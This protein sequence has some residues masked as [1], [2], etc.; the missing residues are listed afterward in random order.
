M[1][2]DTADDDEPFVE[3]TGSMVYD[4]ESNPYCLGSQQSSMML[5]DEGGTTSR[6]A[7]GATNG[8]MVDATLTVAEALQRMRHDAD[9]LKEL[10]FTSRTVAL[11][12]L[13]FF[14]WSLVRARDRFFDARDEILGRLRISDES[15]TTEP[16]V[17]RND[18][19]VTCCICWDDVPPNQAIALVSCSHWLCNDCAL[20]SCMFAIQRGST[21]VDKRCP[22]PQCSG[23][24][25]EVLFRSILTRAEDIERYD[26]A[27][28]REYLENNALMRW[29]ANPKGR[30]QHIIRVACNRDRVHEVQC[31]SCMTRFCF[32]CSDDAHAPAT[33]DMMQ[34]WRKKAA[35]DSET[36]NWVAANTKNCPKCQGTIEKNGGCNH[37]VCTNCKHE[38]CWVCEGD[39]SKHGSS[40]YKCNFFDEGSDTTKSKGRDAAKESL[41]RYIF[42][43]TRYSNHLNSQKLDAKVMQQVQTRMQE[44]LTKGDGGD[45]IRYLA[46]TALV[47]FECRHTLTYTYVYAFYLEDGPEKALFEY[48][49]AQLEFS[50][51]ELSMVIEGST[52]MNAQAV[53]DK[54][55]IAKK[56]HMEIA[57]GIW[58]S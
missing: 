26:G 10:A 37:M 15:A 49:Q 55:A 3:A 58:V 47:L 18:V 20:E 17:Q 31:A 52:A 53:M 50:T 33:C 56:F 44:T 36:V 48:Q 41:K 14:Q 7:A 45:N 2:C 13:K 54:T 51:E 38:W 34:R 4:D 5:V 35:D 30:C 6:G 11:I 40:W 29:C 1:M 42:Y 23:F 43:Y 8:L 46:D 9:D 16:D 12:L 19:A 57:K 25:G 28:V 27:L 22:G 24:T 32:N 21:V 39:W